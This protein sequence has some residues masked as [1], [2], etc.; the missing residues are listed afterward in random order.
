[1][2]CQ[3]HLHSSM[4]RHKSCRSTICRPSPCAS[5]S[6]K[7]VPTDENRT[8]SAGR[9]RHDAGVSAEG[10]GR[11]TRVVQGQ[12]PVALP[13]RDS[14][15]SSTIV[16]LGPQSGHDLPA[17]PEAVRCTCEA[18]LQ[19]ASLPLGR[20][21]GQRPPPLTVHLPAHGVSIACWNN[22]WQPGRQ[23]FQV[24]APER[25]LLSAGLQPLHMRR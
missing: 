18:M 1:M 24:Q 16:H 14:L 19:T 4:G 17:K 5:A 23:A 7:P 8:P 9:R 21:S 12:Q 6:A 13:G 2:R 15:D 11:S 20:L 22:E 10:R 3:A 25:T